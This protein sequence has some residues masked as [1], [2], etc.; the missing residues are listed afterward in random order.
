M[1]NYFSRKREFRAD[2]GGAKYSSR[3]SMI[4]ALQ[5]L[6]SVYELPIPAEQGATATLMISNRPRGGIA[7]LFMTH[8]PLSERIQTLQRGR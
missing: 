8:P 5:R 2:A 1:V 4:A 7:G 6:Q 3:Q